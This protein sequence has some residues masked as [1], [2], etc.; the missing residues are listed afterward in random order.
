M[1]LIVLFAHVVLHL[2][3]TMGDV[4]TPFI[5]LACNRYSNI[6]G[7]VVCQ[8]FWGGSSFHDLKILKDHG[9]LRG[10]PNATP[11]RNKA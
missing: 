3:C 6:L 4:I 5:C 10:P 8:Q 11:P 2:H 7:F 9:N 1:F